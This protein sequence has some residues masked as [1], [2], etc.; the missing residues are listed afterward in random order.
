MTAVAGFNPRTAE[1]LPAVAEEST[2]SDVDAKA[3]AAA[4]SA[5]A[6]VDAGRA[7][8]AGLLKAIADAIESHR[9]AL[10]STAATETGFT[11]AKLDGELTRTVFQF[12]FFAEVVR[13]GSYLEAMIDT[14]GDTPMGSRPDLRRMLVP[15]GPVA[16]FGASNFPFAFSVLGGDTASALAAGCPV[17]AKAHESH[18]A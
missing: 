4:Q 11:T 15:I 14:A 2:P 10:V 3:T 1:S 9:G 13:E 8:R 6:L 17:I 18:P 12:R 7:G 16:V 5:S